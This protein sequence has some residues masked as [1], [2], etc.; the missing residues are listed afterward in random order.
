M[1]STPKLAVKALIWWYCTL[2]LAVRPEIQLATL[3]K[4]GLSA[5]SL[6][7][8]QG[9]NCRGLRIGPL[10]KRLSG[11]AVLQIRA[12]INRSVKIFI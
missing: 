10:L 8:G 2:G 12:R 3:N 6:K 9:I 4:R 1:P 5:L 11:E 7:F